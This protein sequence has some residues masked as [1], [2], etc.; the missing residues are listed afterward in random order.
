MKEKLKKFWNKYKA[1]IIF[2]TLYYIVAVDNFSRFLII[3]AVMT[4][5]ELIK[6]KEELKR[7]KKEN[8]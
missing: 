2:T 3:F 4:T 6:I 7:I 5:D 1:I 8:D